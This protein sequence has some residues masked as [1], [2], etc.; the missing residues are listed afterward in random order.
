[1]L[2]LSITVFVFLKDF[3]AISSS[4]DVVLQMDQSVNV[5]VFIDFN[6][7]HKD[8]LTCSGGGEIL[9]R[10]ITLKVLFFQIISYFLP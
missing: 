6:V 4:I 2:P 10:L 1:M 8:W 3:C 9:V 5:F 7:Q